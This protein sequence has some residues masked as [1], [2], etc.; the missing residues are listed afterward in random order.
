[1]MD[2]SPAFGR[3]YDIILIN[4]FLFLPPTACDNGLFKKNQRGV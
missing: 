2:E 1:M 3:E 4:Y